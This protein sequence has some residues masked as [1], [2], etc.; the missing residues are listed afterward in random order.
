MYSGQSNQTLQK[1]SSG[2]GNG[3]A[4]IL[5]PPPDVYARKTKQAPGV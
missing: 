1:E 2:A 3:F 4:G 5:L